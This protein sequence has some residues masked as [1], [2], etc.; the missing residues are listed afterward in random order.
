MASKPQEDFFGNLLKERDFG[1]VNTDDL[2]RQFVE[3][4][5]KNASEWIEK[6]LKLPKRD[7]SKVESVPAPF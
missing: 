4:E 2:A 1:N 3:L 7:E 6:A 5:Q